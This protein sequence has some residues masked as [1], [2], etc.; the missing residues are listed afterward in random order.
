MF[1][2]NRHVTARATSGI[3]FFCVMATIA[4]SGD[5]EKLGMRFPDVMSK[6][7]NGKIW[8]L[9]ADLAGRPALLLVA[10]QRRH[11]SLVDDWLQTV[12]DL[13][14][15]YPLLQV[16]ELP[17][18]AALNP[19]ARWFINSGMR[20]GIPDRAARG[21]TITL[22]L[23]KEAFRS[24]LNIEDEETITAFLLDMDGRVAWRHSGPRTEAA[25]GELRNAL[26]LLKGA[27][28]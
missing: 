8:T 19:A 14:S 12:T 3:L 26:A 9:P 15:D 21:R 25:G 20:G 24:A 5:R 7:L 13:E 4:T 18:I 22:Y 16:L 27:S 28:Q 23:D 17:V 2:G 1:A 10:F 11:Q 6:D